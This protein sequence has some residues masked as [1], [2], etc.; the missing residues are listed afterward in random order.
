MKTPFKKQTVLAVGA[1]PDDI[2]F[3]AAG[4]IAKW[5]KEGATVYY[6]ICTNGNKG[7]DDP[8]M[9]HK[10]LARIRR[11]EQLTAARILGVKKVFFLNYEDGALENSL[12]LK[13]KIARVIRETKPNIVITIDPLMVYSQKRG[14]INHSDHRACGQATL[15]AIYP[16]ARD[17]LSF[18]HHE[19]RGFK[20]HK[21]EEVYLTNFDK[22]DTFF[23]I[24][25][26]IDLKIEAIKA[27]KSQA[28]EETIKR[29]KEWSRQTGK[30]KGFKF[31]EGFKRIKINF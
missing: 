4:T 16:L 13:E 29:I 9:T 25:K 11:K 3:S 31:G 2:D 8:K 21:V 23:N 28:S 7:S 6:L 10:K 14:Y 5:I 27:H 20:P 19:R 24:T 30:Q 1:H 12:H 15:D 22:R 18:P 26:T 17:R